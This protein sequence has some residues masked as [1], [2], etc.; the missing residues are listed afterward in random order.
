MLTHW[1]THSHMYNHTTHTS[2]ISACFTLLSVTNTHTHTCIIKALFLWTAL[3]SRALH[4]LSATENYF[5]PFIIYCRPIKQ[6]VTHRL[7]LHLLNSCNLLATWVA[8]GKQTWHLE[9]VSVS[10]WLALNK[11]ATVWAVMFMSGCAVI[12]FC[13]ERGMRRRHSSVF[14]LCSI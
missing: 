14:L 2:P 3:F 1:H 7:V 6:N 5:S 13:V 8:N 12:R 9:L 4:N 11:R 10:V